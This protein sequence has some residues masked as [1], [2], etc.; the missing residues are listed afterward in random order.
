[1]NRSVCAEGKEDRMR[2]RVEAS[3]LTQIRGLISP[4]SLDT[5]SREE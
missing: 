2:R 5:F 3:I 1:V 4:Q